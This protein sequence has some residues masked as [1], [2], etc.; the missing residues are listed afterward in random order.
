MGSI[1]VALENVSK[2][3]AERRGLAPQWQGSLIA[4]ALSDS[5]VAA[6]QA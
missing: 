6:S 3:E 5:L 1:E 4:G 2:F